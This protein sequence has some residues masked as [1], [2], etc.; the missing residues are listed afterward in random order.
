MKIPHWQAESR[1]KNV[2]YPL[3]QQ[4]MGTSREAGRPSFQIREALL[5]R[6]ETE[7]AAVDH[8][9]GE[10]WIVRLKSVAD[11]VDSLNRMNQCEPGIENHVHNDILLFTVVT[12]IENRN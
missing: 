9:E 5:E 4:P 2:T 8:L 7:G 11:E 12:K 10:A 3:S 1:V 6:G